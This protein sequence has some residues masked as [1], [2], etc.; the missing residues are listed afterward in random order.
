[1]GEHLASRTDFPAAAGVVVEDAYCEAGCSTTLS[2]VPEP[3]TMV[4]LGSALMLLASLVR[5]AVQERQ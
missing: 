4:L 1:L 3:A 2:S 5:R